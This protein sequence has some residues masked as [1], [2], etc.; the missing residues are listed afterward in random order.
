METFTENSY[1]TRTG[2]LQ[3]R[4]LF[5]MKT[6]TDHE[7]TYTHEVYG[8]KNSSFGKVFSGVDKN[9]T[10]IPTYDEMK[11]IWSGIAIKTK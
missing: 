10:H 3:N 5:D 7:T 2:I 9:V 4:T 11:R 8:N 1:G 6:Q